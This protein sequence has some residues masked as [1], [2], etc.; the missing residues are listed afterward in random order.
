MLLT[1]ARWRGQH[2]I[3]RFG[4]EVL[5][6][7]HLESTRLRGPV[8]PLSPLDLLNPFRLSLGRR[9]LVYTPGFNAG[10]TLARQVLTV[11]DLIH[12][13]H[14]DEASWVKRRYYESVVRPAIKRSGVVLTVSQSSKT[15][16]ERWLDDADVRVADVGN[17]CADVF[18]E[19]ATKEQAGEDL[20]FVGNLKP[21]KNPTVLFRALAALDGI[22]LTTVTADA[23]GVQRLVEQHGLDGRVRVVAG[24]DDATL[25]DL[26]AA[27][28]ALVMPSL[29]EGFGLPAVEA[30]ASGLPVVHWAGC[31]PLGSIIGSYG[32]AVDDPLD[33]L[34]WARAIEQVLNRPR[35][36]R[37]SPDGWRARYSW[38]AVARRVRSE[39]EAQQRDQ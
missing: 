10:P 1:D 9:D 11:H 8:D 35:P 27:H 6:R 36:P 38:D 5:G 14:A 16:I 17:G 20:L 23:A 19:P 3:A 24:C 28:R 25:R 15:V 18:F 30:I 7:L 31:A 39:L 21:H 4:T 29:E 22:R 34:A 2:G 33:E 13:S 26:Y 32:T 12:L 37:H